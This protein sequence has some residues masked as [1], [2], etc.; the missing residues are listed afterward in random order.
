MAPMF[1]HDGIGRRQPETAAPW[2]GGEI[3]I[4]YPPKYIGR[5]AVAVVP[6]RNPYV[7]RGLARTILQ[8]NIFGSN[9]DR[10]T[11]TRCLSSIDENIVEHLADLPRIHLGGPQA[12]H[13]LKLNRNRRAGT[14]E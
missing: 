6:D 7:R 14:G 12:F 8:S 3:W 5:N 11:T 2:L 9:F 13:N 4:K 1:G 10:A